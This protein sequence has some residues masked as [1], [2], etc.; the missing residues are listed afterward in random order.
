MYILKYT[1]FMNNILKKLYIF[2]VSIF[3]LA[4]CQQ[5]FL[6]DENS[7]LVKSKIAGAREYFEEAISSTSI[8]DAQVQTKNWIPGEVTPR[9]DE[10][11]TKQD[12]QYEYV[13]V[14]IHA[15]NHYVGEQRTVRDSVKRFY[16]VRIS[17]FLGIRKNK[18]G[19]YNMVYFT[20]IPYKPYY[21][22]HKNNVESRFLKAESYYGDFTGHVVY[23]SVI[24]GRLMGVDKVNQGKF[25]WGFW[26]DKTV[27]REE[28]KE[29]YQK[30]FKNISVFR[31]IATK[32]IYD[33]GE[34]EEAVCY[35]CAK[36]QQHN[37]NLFL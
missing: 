26:R 7:Q 3:L 5:D 17:Q 36:C 31:V 23:N 27:S 25:E 11:T 22:T 28:F 16:H 32:T 24:R 15:Q 30:M 18:E 14:P 33:G 20:L 10:A 9:W 13:F 35:W 1:S 12:E 8:A 21:T 29:N 19:V 6:S 37:T 2:G 4:S 34:L